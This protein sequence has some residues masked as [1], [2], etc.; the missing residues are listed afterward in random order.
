MF[1]FDTTF[2]ESRRSK[3]RTSLAASHLAFNSKTTNTDIGKAGE[4]L[5]ISMFE[6]AGYKARKPKYHGVDLEVRDPKSGEFFTVEVKTANR[7]ECRKS[8]QFCLNKRGNTCSCNSAYILLIL[9]AEKT[10]FTYLLPSDFLAD[11]KQFTISSHP[12]KYK[13]KIAP[14]RNRG[15]LSFQAARNVYDLALLQ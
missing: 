8:W 7:T 4:R 13:G 12:E 10:V 2:N 3:S 15:S 14:F 5:A 9:I 1:A 6:E 11:T